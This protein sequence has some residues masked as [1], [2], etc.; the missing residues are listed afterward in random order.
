MGT[1]DLKISALKISGAREHNLKD[2]ALEIPHD[3]C[4]VVT[5]LSGSGKS[6]LA[7]DTV[8]AEG[9]RRYIETFSPYTRQFFDKVKKPDVDLIEEVRP[10]VAIEQRTRISNSRSTVGSITNINDLLKVVWSNLGTPVCPSCHVPV[11]AWTPSKLTKHLLK[12]LPIRDRESFLLAAR[13]PLPK[14]AKKREEERQRLLTLGYSRYF[15]VEKLTV[16]KL[17]TGIPPEH[18]LLLVLDRFKTRSIATKRLQE[19]I[20][21]SFTVSAESAP[22]NGSCVVIEMDG[23]VSLRRTFRRII[24]GPGQLNRPAPPLPFLEYAER[25]SC[26]CQTLEIPKARP[27]LFSF[28]HPLGACPECKGFGFL[29]KADPLRCVPDRTKSIKEHALQCW[30]GPAAKGEH[31]R[32][33]RFCEDQNISTSLPWDQLTATQQEQIFQAKTREYRGVAHWFKLIERKS[34]KMHVRVFLAKYRSQFVCETCQGSRLKSGALAYRI[35]GLTIADAWRLPLSELRQWFRKVD[36]QFLQKAE[37]PRELIDLCASISARLD[38]LI[39]LGLPYVTLDRQARTLS[40]GETQRVNLATALGSNLVSTHFVLD[41]PSVGLHARDSE[42][43]IAAIKDLCAQGNSLLVVEHDPQIIAQADHVIELGPEAGA[44]GGAIVYNG[45]FQSWSGLPAI[46]SRRSKPKKAKEFLKIHNACARNLKNLSLQIPTGQ[47][48]SL[49]GVSGSG[50]SSLVSEVLLASYQA[51]KTQLEYSRTENHVEGFAAFTQVLMVDQTP[52][53]KSPRANI[54]TYTGIWDRIRELLAETDSAQNRALSKSSF[55]FNVDGGRCPACKGAGYVTEEMQFLSDVYIPCDLCAGK[56]FQSAVLEVKLQDLN[57]HEILQLSVARCA[58]VFKHEK[59][60]Q[61]AAETLNTL[62]LGH[63]TLGHP[64]S[65]LSGG[66]AQRLKLVPFVSESQKG[67]SLLIFD[68]P[69]T[70]LHVRDTDRFIQLLHTLVQAGHSVICVEH[71]L[72]VIAASDWMIDLGPEGGLGGGQ[73]I[74]EGNPIELA[75]SLEAEN[76]ETLKA[77]RQHL[78]PVAINTRQAASLKKP[79]RTRPSHLKIRGANE[80]NLKEVDLDIPLNSFVAFT[81]VSGSGKSSIA[82]DIIYAEGQRRY[83]DC[84][85]PYARQFIKELKKPEVRS[86]ENVQPTICVYQHTFQPGR[87]STVGTMSEAYNFMRLLYAKVG[88]QYCPDHPDQAITPLSPTEIARAIKSSRENSVRLLAPII[89]MKKGNHKAIIERALNADLIEVRIDGVFLKPGTLRAMSGGLERNKPHSIDFVFAKFNPQSVDLALIKESVQQGLAL[90]AGTLIVHSSNNEQVFSLERACAI[91]K[92]G[93]FKPDP[94]EL[95]FHSKRGA[96]THC[97]GSGLDDDSSSCR[98]CQG[99]RLHKNGLHIR[100]RGKN[101]AEMSALAPAAIIEELQSLN[102]DPR[103]TQMAQPIITELLAKLDTLN[104]IGLEYLPLS[105]DCRSLSNG[106]LQR[107]RLATAMGSPLTGVMYIFDEPSVGLHPQDNKRVLE[108]LKKLTAQGNSVLMIEH[109]LESIRACTHV[110]EVGP[111]GGKHGGEIVFNGPLSKLLEAE[112]STAQALRQPSIAALKSPQLPVGNL[113]I[114]N[115]HRNCTSN[116]NIKIPL[117]NLITVAGVSGAGKSTLVHGILG[118]TLTLGTEKEPMLHWS[119]P[120]ADVISDIEISRVLL[121]DQNPIGINSRSTPASYLGIWDDIRVLFASSVDAKARG[122]TASFFSYNTGKGRCSACKGQGSITLEMSFLADAQM[123]CD[124]CAGLRYSEEALSVRYLGLTVA[125]VL[126]LTFEEARGIF[127]NHRRIH[128]T[129]QQA[130]EL[131]LGYLTLGQSS[132]TLSGGESQR[133]KL[134]SELNATR[135]GHTLY[136][137]DE[138]TTGLHYSDVSKLIKILRDLVLRGNTVIVIEHD[139]EMLLNSDH[140]IEMGPGPG[141]SGGKV[142]F[143][144]NTQD[145]LRSGSA[146][147]TFLASSM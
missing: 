46:P 58:E 147:G 50:K 145:L 37:V 92:R 31:R 134:V 10:A 104:R 129:L 7:F 139:P 68:E 124:T 105:R 65:A 43:L 140:I 59:E 91:C 130:C 22:G 2:L 121:V 136:L 12:I 42:R 45:P 99:T 100:L 74:A 15:H 73:L 27:S 110:V 90:G 115:A 85:S 96:C 117:G 103:A 29:L 6:S 81:G 89:K 82:K 144:G 126:A 116:L 32:L 79:L 56:R 112:T 146:W 102:L 107:L 95:S 71:N 119:S 19:S 8:Y 20:T 1:R 13:V 39:H 108:L 93:F 67:K 26:L 111:G 106:E 88:T 41:E 80:H 21:Q 84:L 70:G 132:A 53:A 87:L 17:E 55:S 75:S 141:A 14:Q 62:G 133:I 47:L 128:Q 64:L 76:S 77:L 120:Y 24:N 33:L 143:Q 44:N 142:V 38:A 5:G 131:G 78:A 60:I 83:L 28:N 66:E 51:Q 101:I 113:K 48:V 86:V 36:Q 125:Q 4:V 69:T 123:R 54:A 94:E 23:E 63:L 97:G 16:E 114:K 137:L 49:T 127:A 122:W 30:A 109:D 72:Q 35:L 25:P 135:Q 11:E 61:A 3:S 40:G 34:Y 57:V 9:Q 138:P 98:Y 52:L 18:E 118:H